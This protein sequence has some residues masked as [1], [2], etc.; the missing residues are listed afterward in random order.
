MA[1]PSATAAIF[2][3]P[4]LHS[5]GVSTGIIC[6]TIFLNGT[7]AVRVGGPFAIVGTILVV[8]S[9]FLGITHRMGTSSSRLVASRYG[10]VQMAISRMFSVEWEEQTTR[11]RL[12]TAEENFRLIWENFHHNFG[13][14]P[15]GKGTLK[16]MQRAIPLIGTMMEPKG[17]A[18]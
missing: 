18:I 7:A 15:L 3:C 10:R 16:R 1:L 11:R 17:T 9:H 13:I 5:T 2:C 6:W 14:L 4:T 8:D 12:S